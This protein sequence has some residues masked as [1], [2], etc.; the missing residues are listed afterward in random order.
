[1]IRTTH[2]VC[3][4]AFLALHNHYRKTSQAES[5]D[6]DLALSPPASHCQLFLHILS[7]TWHHNRL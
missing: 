3:T 1:M 2:E 4:Q 7:K 5:L 6:Y